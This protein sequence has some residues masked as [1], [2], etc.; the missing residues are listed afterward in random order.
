MDKIIGIAGMVLAALVAQETTAALIASE[1]FSVGNGGDYVNAQ[2][3]NTAPNS[4][5]LTGNTGFSTDNAW[6]VGTSLIQPRDYDSLTHTLVQGSTANGMVAVRPGGNGIG[7]QVSRD[8]AA[9]PTGSTFY[10]SGLI[11]VHTLTALDPD[12]S[13]A[14][15]LIG[16]IAV[17]TYDI[18]SGLHLG[19]NCDSDG[20]VYL[21]AFAAGNTYHLGDALTSATALETQMI[22]LRLDVNTSGNNDTLT[23][24]IA[25]AG[26]T[27]LTQ[28]LSVNNID[29]GTAANLKMFVVQSQGGSDSQ[30][31]S[32][33]RLDEFRFGTTLNDV[34]AIPEPATIST[35]GV[36]TLLVLLARRLAR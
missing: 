23:G 2:S 18:S 7:R 28:V 26:E 33:A 8:L 5:N 13:A 4:T 36:G 21:S 24:W 6:A 34:A 22:V 16:S 14:M 27:N 29:T 25:Q 17:N 1:S 31:A 32:G 12:E 30:T 3:F 35:L 20:N 15:G 11:S 10:M 9:V 19:V